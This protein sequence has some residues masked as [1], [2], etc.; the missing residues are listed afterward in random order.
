ME[1]LNKII[2]VL[3][4]ICFIFLIG[5]ITYKI[6][7][8]N[9]RKE[10]IREKNKV[11]SKQNK[12]VKKEETEVK[13][14]I[15]YSYNGKLNLKD[16]KIVNK[17]GES[18]QLKGI[19]SHGIQWFKEYVN[20]DN[21]KTLKKYG[22]NVF[23]IAM[24]TEENGY[25]VNKSLKNDAFK[26]MDLVI[27][28]D[29]YVIIDWHI[30]SDG[31]PLKHLNES[32]EF[33]DEVS[34][35]YKDYDNVIYEICNEPNGNVTWD[36]NVRPYAKEVLSVIRKNKKDAIVIVGTPT[37]SQDVD[38][39]AEHPLND[40]YV[41]YSLHFYSGT[42]SSWLR[43]RAKEALN[44]IPIFVSEWGVSDASG[45]GGVYLDEA[46]KWMSFIN[47]NNLSWV[48]WSLTDK[49]ESSALLKE[50]TNGVVN[51]NNLSESGKYIINQLK[52]K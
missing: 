48:N 10:A 33:F 38:K 26:M 49:N 5:V 39:A 44:K 34:K 41:M 37:W 13:K 3:A 27:K 15:Y 11:V 24:Y 51:D 29:M 18:F 16:K 20:D 40:D 2:T 30:L 21:I 28:N 50:N 8:I 7:T 17:N 52:K 31:D 6:G 45:N 4:L 14:N 25:T 22:A 9:G 12:K 43:D 32:K 36:N 23:R 35:K 1:K 42:H 19:S 47:E 46:D